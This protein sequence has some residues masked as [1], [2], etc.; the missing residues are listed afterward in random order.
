M[1]RDDRLIRLFSSTISEGLSRFDSDPHSALKFP[2]QQNRKFRICL[3]SKKPVFRNLWRF[4]TD[5]NS[6]IRITCLRSGSGSF[7]R[8]Q[9]KVSFFSEVFFLTILLTQGIF[10]LVLKKQ[11]TINSQSCINQSFSV[12]Y[13]C[14]WKDP[15]LEPEPCKPKTYG[16][17]EHWAKHFGLLFSPLPR[18]SS[19][20]K[21]RAPARQAPSTV[22]KVNTCSTFSTSSSQTEQ[23]INLHVRN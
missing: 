19:G 3:K 22:M 14:W 4:D 2:D 21:T 9:Q 1:Y 16:S 15:E 18:F 8:C 10:T 6:L 13:A 17:T 11:V 23:E 5:P 7:L 20:M 12:F